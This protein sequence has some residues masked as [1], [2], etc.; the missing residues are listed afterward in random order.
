ML[1]RQKQKFLYRHNLKQSKNSNDLNSIENIIKFVIDF[2]DVNNA[3]NKI[4]FD[5]YEK[6]NNEIEIFNFRIALMLKS[7]KKFNDDFYDNDFFVNE[8][9]DDEFI[10]NININKKMTKTM[11]TNK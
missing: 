2:V 3:K 11:K 5:V 6:N 1:N 10:K 4:I 8:N 9:D 7:K